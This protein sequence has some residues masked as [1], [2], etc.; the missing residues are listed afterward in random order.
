MD[1]D[2]ASTFPLTPADA[3]P[4]YSPSAVRSTGIAGV[5]LI[6]V[7]AAL[8]LVAMG[9]GDSA[10]SI[11]N[12]TRLFLVFAGA[13]I[14]GAGISMRPDLWWSW[15][16]G[17]LAS[18]MAVFGLPNTWDSFQMLFS[19]LAGVAGA[20]AVFCL[21]P[22]GWRYAGVAAI[23]LF[24]FSGIFFATT[25]PP[26][27]PWLTDQMFRRIYNPYL[28]FAYLR[29]AYHFYS[30]EPGPASVLVFFLKTE[31]GYDPVTEKKQYQTQWI[32]S[33][34]RP[35][36][37]RDP[38]GLEYYRML[39][40]NEQLA[41]GSH[42][43]V[44]GNEDFERSEMKVRRTVRAPV[45]PFHPVEPI[46]LQY[47]VPNPEVMR[48]LLPSYASHMILENTPDKETARKTTV[49]VYRLEH[50]DLLPSQMAKGENP[51]HPGTYRPYFLGEF[52]VFGKLLNPQEELLYWML[53]VIPR[54]PAPNDPDDP[55]RKDYFDYLSVHALELTSIAEVLKADE[56]AGRVFKWSQL[57]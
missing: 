9:L 31:T 12:A 8:G 11:L 40:L 17:A 55:Y 32:P 41:R 2:V 4:P 18:A 44:M 5:A 51:Y 52:D 27:S 43:L 6:G 53:P 14:A 29:N 23:L 1:R 56:N 33:P 36:N 15:G 26:A 7:A 30:P 57:R 50:R 54:T 21:L 47:K 35:A 19:V 25:A 28:Q 49:K 46:A 38:M 22:S 3:V 24:H 48:Y 20:G 37:V 10:P 42:A 16:F 34:T 13:V 39:S 45:I